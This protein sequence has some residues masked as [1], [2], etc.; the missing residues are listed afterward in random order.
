LINTTGKSTL[1]VFEDEQVR[2]EA[3]FLT[4]GT[5]ARWTSCFATA[6]G[7]ISHVDDAINDYF[8]GLK[9]SV[10]D[11]VP[12]THVLQ[13]SPGARWNEDYSNPLSDIDNSS[14]KKI[15]DC[16]RQKTMRGTYIRVSSW[17]AD[18]TNLDGSSQLLPYIC[19]A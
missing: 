5:E 12:L 15:H 14:K 2:H 6:D 8:E 11:G 10:C 18:Q 17:T 16:F 19:V 7:H 13:M 9:N 1:L 4:G 3:Y